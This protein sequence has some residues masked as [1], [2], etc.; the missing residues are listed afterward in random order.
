MIDKTPG[1][2]KSSSSER[3]VLTANQ[4]E[5]DGNKGFIKNLSVTMAGNAIY[6]A[7]KEEEDENENEEDEV[8]VEQSQQR[9][10]EMGSTPCLEE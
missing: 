8:H 7:H 4:Q 9:P 6:E 2:I 1:K 3:N 5:M 10:E